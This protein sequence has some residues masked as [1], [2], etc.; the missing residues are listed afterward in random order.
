MKLSKF[1]SE[2][3]VFCAKQVK[4]LISCSYD[5][6]YDIPAKTEKRHSQIHLTE[7][8]LLRDWEKI[9]LTERLA[10]KTFLLNVCMTLFDFH[11]INYNKF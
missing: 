10:T 4:I 3:F 11:S 7:Y 2:P 9:P 1:L 8:L 5:T 6:W